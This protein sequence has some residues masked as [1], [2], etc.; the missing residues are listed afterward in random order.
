MYTCYSVVSQGIL[1]LWTSACLT[2]S[3]ANNA[4][5]VRFPSLTHKMRRTW[6]ASLLLLAGSATNALHFYLDANQKRCFIEELP[7]DTVVEG[8]LFP[9]SF[10]F[11]A[12]TVSSDPRKLPCSGMGRKQ[13]SLLRESRTGHHCSGRGAFLS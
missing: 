8:I 4:T 2:S 12:L 11:P 10:C 13:T 1:V 9:T 5:L 6:L 7:T 3:N